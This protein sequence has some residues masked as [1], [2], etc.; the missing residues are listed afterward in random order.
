M[1]EESIFKSCLKRKVKFTTSTFVKFLIT[2]TVALSLTACGGGG[3]GGGSSSSGGNG[4]GNSSLEKPETHIKVEDKKFTTE[5]NIDIS[6]LNADS[7]IAILGTNSEIINNK[8]ITVNDKESLVAIYNSAEAETVLDAFKK[9]GNSFA[10]FADGGSVTNA[11]EGVLEIS[12]NKVHAITGLYAEITNNGT[13]TTGTNKADEAVGIFSLGGNVTNNGDIILTSEDATGIN[14]VNGAKLYYT[15]NDFIEIK[16]K[17]KIIVLNNKNIKVTGESPVGISG[18]G[19]DIEIING[20]KGNIIVD[21]VITKTLKGI[22][23]KGISIDTDDG[24]SKSHDI[25]VTNNGKITVNVSSKIENLTDELKNRYFNSYGIYAEA[26]TTTINNNKDIELNVTAGVL[27]QTSAGIKTDGKNNIINNSENITITSKGKDAQENYFALVGIKAEGDNTTIINKNINISAENKCTEI[28]GISL[29]GNNGTIENSGNIILNG[30][31]SNI[32]NGIKVNGNNKITNNGNITITGNNNFIAGINADGKNINITNSKDITINSENSSVTGIE[33]SNDGTG[34][35]LNSGT[36]KLNDNGDKAVLI[37]IKAEKV[38]VTNS[39]TITVNVNSKV[40]NTNDDTPAHIYLEDFSY[41]IKTNGKIVNEA[42]GTINISG[43][44]IGMTGK[45]V[46]NNGTISITGID[47]ETDDGVKTPIGIFVSGKDSTATNNGNI[48]GTKN[49]TVGMFAYDGATVINEKNGKI[50]TDRGFDGYN[51]H[52][53]N[54]GTVETTDHAAEIS[55]GTLTNYGTMSS[56]GEEVIFI[57]EIGTATNEVTGTINVNADGF[58]GICADHEKYEDDDIAKSTENAKGINKGTINVNGKNSS[59]MTANAGALVINETSGIINISG[60]QSCGIY[61]QIENAEIKDGEQNKELFPINKGTINITGENSYG[62]VAQTIKRENKDLIGAAV[63]NGNE[64]DFKNAV[65]N[66]TGNNSIGMLGNNGDIINYGKIN[67]TGENSVGMKTNC[68]IAEGSSVMGLSFADNY[69]TITVTGNNSIGMSAENGGRVTNEKG[70][71]IN[72]KGN[73]SYAMKADGVNSW[74]VN[75]E[76]ATINVG[77][78]AGGA[79]WATN[80]GKITNK[81]TINLE[82]REGLTEDNKNGF[83]MIA[84][85]NSIIENNGD[86]FIKDALKIATDS[87]SAYIIGTNK[88]GS[89]G[90]VSAETVTV[91]GNVKVSAE[92]AKE[93]YKDSYVLDDAI[94]GKTELKENYKLSSTS[95]LYNAVSKTDEEGNLDVELVRNDTDISDLASKEISKVAGIFDNAMKDKTL[96]E[97]EKEIL[98]KVF[99]STHSAKAVD[100]TIK[101]FTGYNVYSNIARQIFDTKDMFVSYDKSIIDSLGDYNFNFNFIGNYAD[102]NS[103]NKAAGYDSR[104]TGINGAVRFTD[105]LYGV[106]GYGYNDVDYDGNSDGTIETIHTGIYKDIKSQ[107]GNIRTGIFGEYNFHETD[108]KVFDEKTNSDF[109][110]YLVGANVE[111]SRKFGDDL[112]IKP[113]LSFDLSYGKYEDFKEDGGADVKF[114]KQDYVSAVPGIELKLG[115]EFETSEIY[116]AVKYSYE[117]GDLNKEQEIEFLNGKAPIHAD[118]IEDA[119]TDVKFGASFNIKNISVNAE[120]GKEF[121]KRDREYVKA[122]ISYTF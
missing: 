105:S 51:G 64:K 84:D 19:S 106:I 92:M 71:I 10:I 108:R 48:T 11:E 104:V 93:G 53:I 117:L 39:G 12:G 70:G 1:M 49:F 97:K 40:D 21:N 5:E 67:V 88:D 79:M 76:G 2:G 68:F 33:V 7:V 121:G 17:G 38:D 111:I 14:V 80:S 74:A 110:S 119:Q 90:K 18:V 99:D 115:K 27:Q 101:E 32:I 26:D 120:L 28:Y 60:T 54:Y 103:K 43:T 52:I 62:M 102:V 44:A 15:D 78:T 46:T 96:S 87:T 47:A 45:D 100:D 23:T 72:V 16:N 55:G 25:T 122:G 24:N 63:L 114:E 29:E 58:A 112:Y 61:S 77:T 73:G 116:G 94:A 57:D 6:S 91:D 107:F 109:N 95:L 118:N 37:G 66:V 85:D 69:G 22:N 8:K 59:G 81:G 42:G 113:A 3:G 31:N 75:E 82:K 65:I 56:K 30:K 50:T 83:A 98:E 34:N 36:I 20:E 86:V 4:G 41:G 13:I 35:I 9:S 89:Y